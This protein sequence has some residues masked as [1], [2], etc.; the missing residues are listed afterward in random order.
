[1]ETII[2]VSLILFAL[3][4]INFPVRYYHYYWIRFATTKA[5]CVFESK[6]TQN[7]PQC[8]LSNISGE[9]EGTIVSKLMLDTIAFTQGFRGLIDLVREPLT[10]LF[11]LDSLFTGIGN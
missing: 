4:I 6:C 5:M 1:M 7:F 11:F 8:L 3:I 10:A 2:K 9:K